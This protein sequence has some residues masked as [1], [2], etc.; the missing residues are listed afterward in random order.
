MARLARPR[1]S[2]RN[3]AL[4][5]V[6][7]VVVLPLVLV[8][9]SDMGDRA[10]ASAIRWRVNQLGAETAEAWRTET[11]EI[12]AR[13]TDQAA[14]LYGGRVRVLGPDGE[15]LTDADHEEGAI[16]T[17]LGNWVF[18]GGQVPPLASLDAARPPIA[19][20]PE[21]VAALT[22]SV[23]TGCEHVE[24]EHVLLCWSAR[25][26]TLPSGEPALI[27]AEDGSRRA[28]RAL[29]DVRYQ[30]IKLTLYMLAIGLAVGLWFAWRILGPI[31]RLRSHLLARPGASGG[32][33]PERERDDE[34]GDLA[35]A[36]DQLLGALDQRNA[37]NA[38]FMAD[39]VHE[40]KNPVAAVRACADA[41]EGDRPLDADRAKR[42][43]R[44]LQDSSRRLDTL[45]TRF[46]EIARAEAGLPG[47]DRAPV[48]LHDV[49]NGIVETFRADE[50]YAS[51]TFE[52]EATPIS[53]PGVQERLETAIRNLVDNAATFAGPQGRVAV[54]VAAAEG[55]AL[56]VVSDSGP[57]VAEEDRGKLFQR[58]FTKRPDGRGTGLGLP[59]VRAIAEA[60]GGRV[61]AG[62]GPD[63]GAE[64]RVVLP[65]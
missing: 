29:Y 7:L 13:R 24:A 10:S 46:L 23:Q 55:E 59:L 48:A 56:V 40:M 33:V 6:A 60:H 62:R 43:S 22:G 45:V 30:L 4:S 51:V 20:R 50:R 36:F 14:R 52:L 32:P 8:W 61:E 47:V 53:V 18:F 25:K 64:F 28:L 3:R 5:V 38:A 39:L 2:I 15:I 26:A 1:W 35:R 65:G 63:G 9:A 54:R 42:L 27:Y 34:I 37:A 49:A 21:S 57:G 12:A 11:P 19:Q 16:W 41:M 17:R 31:E 58:F 44:V